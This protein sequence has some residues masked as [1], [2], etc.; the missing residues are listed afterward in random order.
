MLIIEVLSD[1]TEARDRGDKFSHYKSIP[2]FC[3]YLLI[4]QHRLHVTQYLKRGDGFWLQ[5]EYNSLDEVVKIESLGCEL[6]MK[7]IYRRVA[8]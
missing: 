3:E 8:F 6:A 1:S 2:S 7:D 4:A 5:R